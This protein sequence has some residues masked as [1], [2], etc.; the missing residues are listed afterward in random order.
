MRRWS[1]IILSL[2]LCFGMVAPLAM[3][4]SLTVSASFDNITRTATI[5]GQL[6]SEEGRIISVQVRNP[7]NQ[8]DYLN[9]SISGPDGTYQFIYIISQEV[10][11]AYLV[12]VGGQNA[13]SLATAT[14]TV[15]PSI[16]ELESKVSPEQPD[17]KEGWYLHPVTV[18]IEAT[19]GMQ[20]NNMIQYRINQ[21]QWKTYTTAID[22]KTDG[23]HTIEYRS[24]DQQGIPGNVKSTII[25]LDSKA[26]VTTAEASPI[27]G[28][29][30]W[31]KSNPTVNLMASDNISVTQTVYRVD[32]SEWTTYSQPVTLSVSGIHTLEY[33][34]MD[35]AGNEEAVKSLSLK[36]DN[37]APELSVTLDKTTLWPANKKLVT[38]TANVY[39]A[40]DISQT[41][42]IVLTSITS[43]EKLQSDD[44]QDAR[45][46]MFDTSF[47]LRAERK[48]GGSGRVYTITYTAIDLAGNKT[49]AT[50]IIKVPHDQGHTSDEPL[51]ES[52]NGN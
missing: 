18:T 33:K 52:E 26:P 29:N 45:Y 40:D 24:V 38:V 25:K 9:Q 6:G 36:L 14:F 19:N 12:T 3:A 46:G 21:G 41:S 35:Q 20:E 47:S 28:M 13:D 48:G 16:V 22:V 27:D 10:T 32:G 50:A 43:N 8:I 44:I 31:Y 1:I 5:S 7:L 23:T 42:S 39:A 34:S 17:G 49:I 4:S 11:G 51:T 15:E 37:V 30:G 2:L